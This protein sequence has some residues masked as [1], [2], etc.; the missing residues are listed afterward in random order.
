MRV[1]E[2]IPLKSGFFLR[3][4]CA[5]LL[6]DLVLN[7]LVS[8]LLY[9]P[10]VS[11]L[12]GAVSYLAGSIFVFL[13]AFDI[14]SSQRKT[15][16]DIVRGISLAGFLI[17]V[18]VFASVRAYPPVIPFVIRALAV[19]YL[20]FVAAS[21][22]TA[23]RRTH[24]ETYRA[25]I[26]MAGASA[27]SAAIHTLVM[28]SGA[29]GSLFAVSRYFSHASAYF[30]TAAIIY[31][32]ARIVLEV[33]GNGLNTAPLAIAV[34]I[35]ASLAAASIASSYGKAVADRIAYAIGIG[36]VF[37][38]PVTGTI[39]IILSVAVLYVL[40]DRKKKT[41]WM[42]TALA[43]ALFLA[44]GASFEPLTGRLAA[45]AA[46]ALFIPEIEHNSRT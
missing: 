1:F 5:V 35:T 7:R 42:Q 41:P 2:L 14:L 11:E 20:V 45:I 18:F 17:A 24:D 26:I 27:V 21:V 9:V 36:K 40:F 46:F 39:V 23:F 29:H 15:K 30:Y 33:R 32:S 10:V 34:F 22:Y 16:T 6:F 4:F 31:F 44:A 38:A 43:A 28:M 12:V 8:A 3:L 25:L 19:C 13:L 37:P